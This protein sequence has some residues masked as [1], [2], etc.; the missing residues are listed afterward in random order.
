MNRRI[1]TVSALPQRPIDRRSLLALGL[2]G[3]ALLHARPAF[4]DGVVVIVNKD[5]SMP[6][7]LAFVGRVYT[8]AMRGWPDGSPVFVLD[9][10]EDSM[11]REVFCTTILKKGVA[12]MK[13]LWSQN[14]FTGKGLPP[15]V[16]G[17]GDAEMKQ[18]VSTNRNAL[19][20]IRESAL[21]DTVRAIRR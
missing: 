12:N 11:A 20:Y 16:A 18:I 5:N 17:A 6:V 1:T 14:I 19:G 2:G 7:D 15:R 3:L 9:Q 21:D 13:A 10:P 8:G 4:A